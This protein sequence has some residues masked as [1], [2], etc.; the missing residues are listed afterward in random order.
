MHVTLE[1]SAGAVVFRDYLIAVVQKAVWYYHRSKIWN[2][3]PSGSYVRV[4]ARAPDVEIKRFS[5][6]YA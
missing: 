6:S 3:R 5:T 2:R 4:A 1:E